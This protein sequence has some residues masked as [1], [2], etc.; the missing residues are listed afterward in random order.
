MVTENRPEGISDR[1]WIIYRMRN[2]LKHTFAMIGRYW[3]ISGT[4]VSQIDADISRRIR[5]EYE[6]EMK[7]P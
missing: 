2:E 1:N 7:K 4:R 3:G 5:W 6:E